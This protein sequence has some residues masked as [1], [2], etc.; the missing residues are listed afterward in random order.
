VADVLTIAFCPSGALVN[1]AVRN[2]L[3]MSLLRGLVVW[4]QGQVH[5]T[6]DMLYR[7]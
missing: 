6:M 4:G 7:S 3:S 5:G 1:R 2:R